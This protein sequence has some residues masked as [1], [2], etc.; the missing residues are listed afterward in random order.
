MSLSLQFT[1][2]ISLQPLYQ[3]DIIINKSAKISSPTQ[4]NPPLPP[5]PSNFTANLSELDSLLDDLNSACTVGRAKSN[6]QHDF[7]E[8]AQLYFCI[9]FKLGNGTAFPRDRSD[10]LQV[11]QLISDLEHDL[12][13]PR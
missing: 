10:S 8:A 3:N 13:H 9:T 2:L 1:S 5:P 12:Q 7:C 11:N 6:F 4:H